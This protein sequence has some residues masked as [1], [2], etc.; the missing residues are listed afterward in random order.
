MRR[1][2]SQAGGA[3]GENLSSQWI[4]FLVASR[5]ARS[6]RRQTSRR[7]RRRRVGEQTSYRGIEGVGD[8]AL[9]C[10]N[11]HRQQTS[12]LCALCGAILAQ[13]TAASRRRR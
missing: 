3:D 7:S 8:N 10:R 12:S 2:A 9:A 5:A 11:K 1:R 6:S 13:Q 4:I